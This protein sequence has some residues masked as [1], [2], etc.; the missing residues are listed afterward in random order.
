MKFRQWYR[1]W[2]LM[3][4]RS[5]YPDYI[6]NELSWNKKNWYGTKWLAG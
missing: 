6:L 2:R 4:K 5:K 3:R 1:I